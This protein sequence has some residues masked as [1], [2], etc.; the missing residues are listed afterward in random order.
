MQSEMEI[1]VQGE[2]EPYDISIFYRKAYLWISKHVT[3]IKLV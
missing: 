3:Y 2:K 1:K